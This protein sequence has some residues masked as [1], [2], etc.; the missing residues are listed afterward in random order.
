[1]HTYTSICRL[2]IAA[3]ANFLN[4]LL[5]EIETLV[6]FFV[7]RYCKIII[8]MVCNCGGLE[9]LFFSFPRQ[10]ITLTTHAIYQSINLYHMKSNNN[11]RLEK[12]FFS[13]NSF[14]SR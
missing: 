2:S 12:Y 4:H 14:P 9:G 7:C 5:E 6:S 13:Y 3:K 8:T 11:N 10:P 1:M